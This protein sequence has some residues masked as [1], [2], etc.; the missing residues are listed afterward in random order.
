MAKESRTSASSFY[1]Q[2]T[3][4]WRASWRS[5][6]FLF[7]TW[8]EAGPLLLGAPVTQP[9]SEKPGGRIFRWLEAWFTPS[10][11]ASHWQAGEACSLNTTP[12]PPCSS[13][14]WPLPT[15][16]LVNLCMLHS[17]AQNPLVWRTNTTPPHHRNH[18]GQSSETKAAPQS[19][20]GEHPPPQLSLL[21]SSI[22]KNNASRITTRRWNSSESELSPIP[23]T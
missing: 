14:P 2:E 18:T 13:V 22:S 1:R 5:Q 9:T 21:G 19:W 20:A 10:R 17:P 8:R 15:P 7:T 12:S 3:Q 6:P 4:G 11:V 16:S 23:H